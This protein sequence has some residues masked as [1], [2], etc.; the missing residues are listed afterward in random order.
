LSRSDRG[1]AYAILGWEI[2]AG[3]C[4]K[5]ANTSVFDVSPARDHHQTLAEIVVTMTETDDGVR[6]DR[7]LS[8]GELRQAKFGRA[9]FAACAARAAALSGDGEMAFEEAMSGI[10][11]LLGAFLRHGP[12]ATADRRAD[13]RRL[14]DRV[15]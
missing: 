1:K 5:P 3:C 13:A 7:I 4:L 6:G 12:A 11:R 2:H 14:R 10:L 8:R 9:E 15:S